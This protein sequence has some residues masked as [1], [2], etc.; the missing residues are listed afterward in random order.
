MYQISGKMS[1]VWV[2]VY[3]VESV[4]GVS[5]CMC[6]CLSACELPSASAG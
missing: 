4:G 5:E 3:V 6:V 2:V 1:P